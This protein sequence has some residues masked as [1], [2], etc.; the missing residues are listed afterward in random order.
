MNRTPRRTLVGRAKVLA[1]A[2]GIVLSGSTV[3][4]QATLPTVTLLPSERYFRVDGTPTA[5]LGTNQTGWDITHF[6]ELFD[7]SLSEER[8][9]RRCACSSA[10][11]VWGSLPWI[12]IQH[13]VHPVAGLEHLPAAR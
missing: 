1:T 6:R 9:V 4:P 13:H 2:M 5:V 3:R 10:P 11:P 7:Y 12:L 8:I